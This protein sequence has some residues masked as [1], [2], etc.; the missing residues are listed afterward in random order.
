L[1]RAGGGIDEGARIDAVVDRAIGIDRS[2]TL[3]LSPGNMACVR[4]A[5]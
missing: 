5:T 2:S 3:K 4:R 1:R